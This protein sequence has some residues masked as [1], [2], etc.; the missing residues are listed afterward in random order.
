MKKAILA[1]IATLSLFGFVSAEDK[2]EIQEEPVC[3]SSFR[4]YNNTSQTVIVHNAQ[5]VD[6]IPSGSYSYTYGECGSPV[7]YSVEGDYKLADGS[8]AT[9]SYKAIGTRKYPMENGAVESIGLT[10]LCGNEEK[11][12]EIKSFTDT[13]YKYSG[14]SK[15]SPKDY[16]YGLKIKATTPDGVLKDTEFTLTNK[17]GK[18]MQDITGQDAIVKT[19]EKGEATVYLYA[20][21]SYFVKESKIDTKWSIKNGEIIVNSTN[22]TVVKADEF[23]KEK[24]EEYYSLTFEN[25]MSEEE[26]AL[27][28]KLTTKKQELSDFKEK[29]LNEIEKIY[30]ENDTSEYNE[31][32]FKEAKALKEQTLDEL[33]KYVDKY[34]NK[35][36]QELRDGIEPAYKF[37]LNEFETTLKQLSGHWFHWIVLALS[38]VMFGLHFVYNKH[39]LINLLLA[40]TIYLFIKDICMLSKIFLVI[41]IVECILFTVLEIVLNKKRE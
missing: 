21:Y 15:G 7:Q 20:G 9:C 22:A 35:L 5:D 1:G 4:V 19:D 18:V 11:T 26:E 32:A 29:T 28:E 14:W 16:I 25:Q 23:S 40:P 10:A 3:R 24:I 37:D 13:I 34:E 41:S 36:E 8:S 12:A 6:V 30:S 39:M 17:D 31:N 38:I 33:N 2:P 27:Q